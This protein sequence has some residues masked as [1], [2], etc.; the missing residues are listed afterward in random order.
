MQP[1]DIKYH[2]GSI[3]IY[4]ELCQRYASIRQIISCHKLAIAIGGGKMTGGILE[5]LCEKQCNCNDPQYNQMPT[6]DR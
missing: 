6:G 5:A 4:C 2:N 3:L 1:S